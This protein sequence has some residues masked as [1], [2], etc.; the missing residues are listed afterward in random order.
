MR[1]H[2]RRLHNEEEIKSQSKV[3]ITS[4]GLTLSYFKI[5]TLGISLSH[6]KD[7]NPYFSQFY[8]KC[9]INKI[10]LKRMHYCRPKLI[11]LR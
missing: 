11:L 5:T 2:E 7:R 9:T 6:Q 3:F 1:F 4:I 10:V 8:T